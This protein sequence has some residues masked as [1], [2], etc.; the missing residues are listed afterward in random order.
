MIKQIIETI[1]DLE[2]KIGIENSDI[3]ELDAMMYSELLTY[4]EDLRK[5]L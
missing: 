5:E 2:T 1:N 4:R 3:E